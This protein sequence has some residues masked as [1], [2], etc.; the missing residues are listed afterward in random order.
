[1]NT[2]THTS[3]PAGDDGKPNPW[4]WI[5]AETLACIRALV[6]SWPEPGVTQLRAVAS[7]RTFPHT[8]H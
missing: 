8:K 3:M 5:D 2:D 4:T 6:A 1:M 7:L